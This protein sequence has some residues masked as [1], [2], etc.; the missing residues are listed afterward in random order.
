MNFGYFP[1]CSQKASAREYEMSLI[2]VAEH[3][4]AG[5]S[6]IADWSCCGATSAHAI[7]HRLS[8]ALAMRN[9]MLAEQQ[10][11]EKLLAPC[12]ACYNR[13]ITARS[14]CRENPEIK[15]DAEEILQARIRNDLGIYNILELF[16]QIGVEKIVHHRV[17]ELSGVNAAC[18]YGCLLVRPENITRFDVAEH[19][20]SMESIVEATGAHTVDWNMKVECCGGAHSIA[21]RDIVLDL[22][23]K[24]LYNAQLHGA[25]VVVVAC[26]MCHTNLDMR[27][28]VMQ[29]KIDNHKPIPVLYLTEL[30]GLAL[31]MTE[32]ELGIDLHY[33]RFRTDDFLKEVLA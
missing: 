7:N 8:N 20:V 25:N 27:Q 30:I 22:S 28:R 21:R 11:H 3:L 14:M 24:I 9:I 15:K 31:G 18:Y 6:E 26:P 16:L 10:D 13:L 1:G 4:G 29:R 12:A 2:K 5:L 17:K 23:H 19:P 32:K 33:V